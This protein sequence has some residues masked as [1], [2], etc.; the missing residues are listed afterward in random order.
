MYKLVNGQMVSNTPEEDAKLETFW[1]A[2]AE[3]MAKVQYK[4]DRR[5]AYPSFA[6]QL[7][8]IYHNGIDKWKTDII[9]PIKKKYPKPE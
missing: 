5:E 7:D 2:E 8:F 4:E 6:D 9:D 3:E 1:K